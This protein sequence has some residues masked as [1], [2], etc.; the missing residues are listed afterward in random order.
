MHSA[1]SSPKPLV[2]WGATGQSKVLAECV[3]YSG[4]EVVALF[5]N[6]PE[7][8]SSLP[9]VPLYHGIAGF[10]RW[11]SE[12]TAREPLNFIVAI[13]GN[14]GK[15]RL[16]IHQMLQSRGLE[17]ISAIH[18]TAFVAHN[19]RLGMGAQVLAQAAVCVE[20]H[21]GDC[22]IINTCAS[23]DHEC[24]LEEGVHVAPGAHLAGCVHVGRYAMI[25]AGATVLPR[26][27][28]GQGAIVGAGSLVVK[29]VSPYTVVFGSP[30]KHL[31]AVKP[32]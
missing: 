21:L 6:N 30:A 1:R 18:P 10:E 16:S 3:S 17:P 22:C 9:G 14:R 26:I 31:K 32:T 11:F 25:G 15:D 29:N 12:W 13:A 19:A 8:V 5:D 28:I 27:G 24:H 7:V 23:V 2:I 20:A 4:Y